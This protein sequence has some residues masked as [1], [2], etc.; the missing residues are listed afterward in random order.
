M[1]RYFLQ[2]KADDKIITYSWQKSDNLSYLII[3]Y[4]LVVIWTHN[5]LIAL[6][7]TYIIIA[8]NINKNM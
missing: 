5:L 7:N 2:Q 3:Q 8:Q 6:D 1:Y 4:I